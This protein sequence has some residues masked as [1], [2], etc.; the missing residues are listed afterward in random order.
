M[1][2]GN[3]IIPFVIQDKER[4]GRAVY[5]DNGDFFLNNLDAA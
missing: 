5:V 3:G 2:P 1:A 4:M